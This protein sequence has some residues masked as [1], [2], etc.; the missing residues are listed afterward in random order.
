MNHRPWRILLVEDNPADRKLTEE[1]IKELSHPCELEFAVDGQEAIEKIGSY[2]FDQHDGRGI[3]DLILLDLNLP[4]QDGMQVLDFL[5]DDGA[6]RKIPVIILTTSNAQSDV[7]CAYEKGA[8]C[9]VTKPLDFNDFVV[10]LKW[11]ENFWLI[12]A[13]RPAFDQLYNR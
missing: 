8:N 6:R 2:D 10:S 11:I 9:F 13:E 12:L 5:K 7:H 1:A 3:P 4:K